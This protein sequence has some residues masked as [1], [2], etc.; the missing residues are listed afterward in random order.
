M[1]NK[2]ELQKGTEFKV[3]DGY[4]KYIDSMGDDLSPVQA[5]RMST[6]KES[7]I[8]IMA[9]DNLRDRLMYD[10]HYSCFQRMQ[11]TVQLE[12]PIF[13]LRQIERHRTLDENHIEI[14][15]LDD[16]WRKYHSRNEFSGRYSE[17]PEKYYIIPEDE[18]RRQ[19]KLNKQSSEGT[20]ASYDKHILQKILNDTSKNTYN[21]YQELLSRGLSREQARSILTFSQ[22]TRVEY[23]ADFLNWC[24]ML[25]LRLKDDVQKETRDYVEII[26]LIINNL[27]PKAFHVAKEHMIYAVTYSQKEQL[28]LTHFM[29]LLYSDYAFITK[30]LEKLFTEREKKRFLNKLG[31]KIT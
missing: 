29:Q 9:D 17:M 6:N 19:S 14:N 5:A 18:L 8:D 16:E 13:V 23:T 7:G 10:K 15:E 21:A 4:V 24:K 31:I 2:G 30:D 3:F 22:Y 28:A 20:F 27:W 11:L 25:T 26:A 1:L 12:L